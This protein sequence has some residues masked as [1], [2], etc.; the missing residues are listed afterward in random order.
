MDEVLGMSSRRLETVS[1]LLTNAALDVA[2]CLERAGGNKQLLAEMAALFATDCP[3][4]MEEISNAIVQQNAAGV[5]R[6]AHA[7]LGSVST[8]S[9]PAATAAARKL[10]SM[11]R[12]G[13]LE[14]APPAYKS[15]EAALQHLNRELAS[16]SA[17]L[18]AGS[19]PK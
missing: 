9:A 10:E 1:N 19:Y 3:M 6:A 13:D 2:A 14:D 4:R 8:F 12:D 7:L 5:E 17:D 16:L 18:S 15:L 11:G